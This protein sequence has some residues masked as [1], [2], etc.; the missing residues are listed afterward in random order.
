[1]NIALIKCQPSEI[2]TFR[3]PVE[4]CQSPTP[5][6]QVLLD[7]PHAAGTMFHIKFTCLKIF[8]VTQDF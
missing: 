7:I 4:L 5:S 8:D 2:S 6:G 1:M 3:I